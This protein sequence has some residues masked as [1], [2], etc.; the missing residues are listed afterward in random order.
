MKI[1]PKPGYGPD[2]GLTSSGFDGPITT[3]LSTDPP[4]H[5]HILVRSVPPIRLPCPSRTSSSGTHPGSVYPTSIYPTTTSSLVNEG[6]TYFPWTTPVWGL[7][8]CPVSHP[9][10]TCL[11]DLSATSSEMGRPLLSVKCLESCF[12]SPFTLM[13]QPSLITCPTV[14]VISPE[15][16]TKFQTMGEYP[17]VL[18]RPRSFNPMTWGGMITTPFTKSTL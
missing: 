6:T 3:V 13:N 8:R 18:S 5:V 15:S 9:R 7:R 10:L 16:L 14:T 12:P 11:P 1:R 2:T 17:W 4:D